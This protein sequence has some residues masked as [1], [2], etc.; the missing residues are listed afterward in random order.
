MCSSVFVDFSEDS[1]SYSDS[2]VPASETDR[3]VFKRLVADVILKFFP[4]WLHKFLYSGQLF[5][6]MFLVLSYFILLHFI[7]FWM[8]FGFQTSK[9]Y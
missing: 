7:F 5:S 3:T 1:A 6:Y 2:S 4:V 9:I 8:L